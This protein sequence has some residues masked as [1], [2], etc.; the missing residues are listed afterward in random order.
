MMEALVSNRLEFVNLLLEHGI[1]MQTFLTAS[2]LE[3][4]YSL[5][6]MPSKLM[7]SLLIEFSRVHMSKTKRDLFIDMK[8]GHQAPRD[9]TLHDIG[10]ACK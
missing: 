6:R 5:E 10:V 9:L 3:A 1:N 8:H 7:R 4:L 2:R